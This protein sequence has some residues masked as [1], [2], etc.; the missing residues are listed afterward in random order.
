[1]PVGH[2]STGG[3][4]DPG[5]KRRYSARPRLISINKSAYPLEAFQ[6]TLVRPSPDLTHCG[7]IAATAVALPMLTG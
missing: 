6:G 2:Q 7:F 3:E 1:M 5:R 4:G